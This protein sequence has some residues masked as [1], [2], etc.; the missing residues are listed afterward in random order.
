MSLRTP[1]FGHDQMTMR[2]TVKM[3]A[4]A[5]AL[6]TLAGPASAAVFDWSYTSDAGA[7]TSSGT[8]TAGENTTNIYGRDAWVV[9]A[10]TGSRNG[11]AITGLARV[12]PVAY[13]GADNY[14][15]VS[16]QPF[17]YSGLSFGL[18]DGTYVNLFNSYEL[19][20]S[21]VAGTANELITS[22]TFSYAAAGAPAVGAVPEP[23]AW[24]MMILGFGLVGGTVRYRARRIGRD[25]VRAG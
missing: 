13:G 8:F 6:M 24:A 19:H 14:L 10:I 5:A 23:A 22:A 16:G 15:Y 11:V 2:T 25:L 21:N 4:A 9:T 7:V 3:I 12:F 20:A 17:T 18:A 1:L